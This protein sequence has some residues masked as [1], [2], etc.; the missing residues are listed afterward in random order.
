VVL[1]YLSSG[2]KQL[3][4]KYDELNSISFV[5]S[6]QVQKRFGIRILFVGHIV[7]K[8]NYSIF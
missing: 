3:I 5:E 7:I 8:S 4:K 1:G 2:A 6:K